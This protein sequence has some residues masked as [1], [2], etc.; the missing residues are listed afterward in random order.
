MHNPGSVYNMAREI[1]LL[2][3]YQGS[4]S[5]HLYYFNCTFAKCTITDTLLL[6]IKCHNQFYQVEPKTKFSW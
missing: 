3:Y 4:A 6:S 2:L 5:V 1:M